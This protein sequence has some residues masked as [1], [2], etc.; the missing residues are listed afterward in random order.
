MGV[1][2]W[3]QTLE[4]KWL[5]YLVPK[6]QKDSH[7]VFEIV[8]NLKHLSGCESKDL[9]PSLIVKLIASRSGI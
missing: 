6:F 5:I 8:Y 1:M 2:F 4:I 3:L 9:N 7:I